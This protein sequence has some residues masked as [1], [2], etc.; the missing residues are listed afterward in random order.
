MIN[1]TDHAV[2][3]MSNLVDHIRKPTAENESELSTVNLTELV[4]QLIAQHQH[5]APL[6]RL[7][8]GDPECHYQSRCRATPK[9]P[10][11]FGTECTGC[12]SAGW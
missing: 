3:K 5:R 6:P 11:A 8:G 12:D 7:E 10:R 9:R 4:T 1:T 2:R